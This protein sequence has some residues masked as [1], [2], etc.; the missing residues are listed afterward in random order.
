VFIDITSYAQAMIRMS[1]SR[2]HECK[3]AV[4]SDYVSGQ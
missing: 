2:T 4:F 1:A 3:R